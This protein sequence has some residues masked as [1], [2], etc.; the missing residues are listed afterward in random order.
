MPLREERHSRRTPSRRWRR[1][2]G[3]LPEVVVVLLVVSAFVIEQYDL[4]DELFGHDA[5]TTPAAV[6]PPEG[7]KLSAQGVADPVAVAVTGGSV[8]PAAV[9]RAL[10]S[11]AAD[12]GLGGHAAVWVSELG[13][14][15]VVYRH[16]AGVVVPASTMKLLTSTAALQVLGPSAR[17][18]TTVRL[19]PGGRVTLVG[20]GDPFLASSKAKAKGI[21]P[22]RADL[23]TLAQ[24][25]AAAL[26]AQQL[27][28]VTLAYD[29]SL[30]TGPRVSPHWPSTYLP[31]DVVP[32]IT[33]LWADEGRGTNDRY[34]ADPAAE[35]AALFAKALARHGIVVR[36]RVDEVPAGAGT[37]EIARVSSAPVGQIVEK[38]LAVSDN[39]A[40]E[41]LAHHVGR[42]TGA[43]ASFAGGATAVSSV[44][45]KLGVPMAGSVL[46]DGS[47]LS[48]ENRLTPDALLAVLRLAGASDHP[49]LREVLTGL[50][51]A[52]FTGS[53]QWRFEKGPADAKGR[54]RAKTGT[55][56]GVSGLAGVA[57]DADGNRMAFVAIADK[58][59]SSGLARADLDQI[60]A[61]LGACRC[62]TPST[63]GP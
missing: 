24:R 54:V 35:A 27:R 7:L 47:G 31:E 6:Q 34:V 19:A 42:V 30:F 46:R 25:T 26:V 18:A 49:R 5:R 53:L 48:R 1:A 21:Y 59:T 3:W 41:V 57:V 44:L 63:T 60:A 32:P 15:R 14:G 29:V 37:T 16:G 23:D 45:G 12:A 62:G 50:P 4:A 38:T 36:G 58:V 8:D 22:A 13:S 43:G 28:T 51:V 55:L 33:A 61:A 52:G 2:L 20:G 9:R 56:T 40:A 39:N 17:F 10:S 11:Y